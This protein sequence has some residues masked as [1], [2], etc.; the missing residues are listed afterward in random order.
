MN[1]FLAMQ[2]LQAFAKGKPLPRGATIHFPISQPKDTL[3][4]AFLKMGGESAPWG[5]AW[6][7]SGKKP[8]VLCVGEPRNRDLVADMMAEFGR[9]SLSTSSTRGTAN[10]IHA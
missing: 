6:A 5:V 1:A 9:S 8:S 10:P 3:F 4:L 2:R 7:T